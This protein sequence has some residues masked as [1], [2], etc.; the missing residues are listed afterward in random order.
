MDL[1][2]DELLARSRF[3][4]DQDGGLCRRGALD[5]REQLLDSGR[6]ADELVLALFLFAQ[7]VNLLLELLRAHG[8][9][10]GEQQLVAIER[11]L[12]KI[13][14]TAFCALDRRLDVAV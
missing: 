2:G 3:S 8:V 14:C 7:L 12:E 1:A 4:L 5:L 6:F 10:D 13:E 11:L 9:A